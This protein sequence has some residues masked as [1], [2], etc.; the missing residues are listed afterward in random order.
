MKLRAVIVDDEPIARQGLAEDVKE[1]GFI[2]VIGVAENAIRAMDMVAKKE[3]GL[4]FLDIEMPKLNGLD[5]LK[6]LKN[7]P[8]VIIT[9]AYPEYAIEGYQL[10]VIDY[11]LKPI[12]FSRLLKACNKAKELFELKQHAGTKEAAGDG[13]FF[14][15]C[16]GRHEKIFLHELL[17]VEA[18]NNYITLHTAAKS[19][20]IYQ[21]LKKMEEYLPADNFIKVHKSYI[22]AVDKISHINGNE[23]IIQKH[24]IPI[25]R[26]FKDAVIERV[27]HK[28]IVK[29]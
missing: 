6:A 22:V 20:L 16:D 5:F 10:D 28:K 24:T 13:H 8:M 11:L 9:T 27:V 15:K 7:P 12:A 23:I 29:R 17:L 26:N 14:I 3:P 2:E 18:A 4:L 25:S 19:F 1:T 21:T